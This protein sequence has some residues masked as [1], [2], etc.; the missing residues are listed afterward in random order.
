MEEKFEFTFV[1]GTV[2]KIVLGED[3]YNVNI[4]TYKPLMGTFTDFENLLKGIAPVVQ[5]NVAD[6]AEFTKFAQELT[7][8]LSNT[9]TI[10]EI[11]EILM[12]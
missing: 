2:I 7:L 8:S 5:E 4:I 6:D 10:D 12:K 1:N 3:G 11:E 9:M